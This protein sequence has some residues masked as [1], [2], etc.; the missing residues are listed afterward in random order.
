MKIL[1][2]P[3]DWGLGH[4]SR[5][6]PIIET[7]LESGVEVILGTCG[8]LKNFFKEAFPQLQQVE[9]PSYGIEYPTHGY[10]MPAWILSQLPR[11][12]KIIDKEH[13]QVESYVSSLGINA[14][15]SD[16]RFGAYSTKI[17][18]VYLTHQLRIAF[19]FA[20]RFLEIIGVQFHSTK[21]SNFTEVW[22]PDIEEFPGYAGRLSHQKI[23]K[24][25]RYIGPLS[26]FY[27]ISSKTPSKSFR[28]LGMVSGVEPMRTRL[29]EKLLNAF[30]SLSGEHALIL[31][32]PSDGL[33]TKKIGNVTLFSHLPKNEFYNLVKSS[34]YFISRPG[35]STIMDQ[36]FLGSNCLFIP[37]P[38][39]TEQVYLGKILSKSKYARVIE[40]RN[41]NK[42]T[43]ESIFEGTPLRLPN[44]NSK[45]LKDTISEFLEHNQ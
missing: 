15:I 11:L 9:L 36:V 16:N 41:L 22:V 25:C 29:E 26:R 18:S 8:P 27:N 21:I 31:G 7:L 14:I 2:A 38:G 6:V 1:V 37:T 40:E 45:L 3:L 12:H 5:C 24:K 13:Q 34:E 4:A 20:S 10:Q 30:Q 43:L 33:N 39:Q 42:D 28:F 32:K 19:P 44:I 35:Y 23:Q 17:P